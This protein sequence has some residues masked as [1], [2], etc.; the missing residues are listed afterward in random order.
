MSFKI[1]KSFP[2]PNNFS[3]KASFRRQLHKCKLKF[4]LD[5]MCKTE[6]YTDHD[7][8]M[9]L[10]FVTSDGLKTVLSQFSAQNPLVCSLLFRLPLSLN[11]ICCRYKIFVTGLPTSRGNHYIIIIKCNPN[12]DID[13]TLRN[14]NILL[15]Y[16]HV[17]V[18]LR[19]NKIKRVLGLIT[20]RHFWWARKLSACQACY[21]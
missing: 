12:N 10:I 11:Q 8:Y 2:I 13:I 18:T 1:D 9:H 14:V 15:A 4:N 20:Y 21:F 7:S 16:R 5:Y 17:T 19:V 6:R 3:L